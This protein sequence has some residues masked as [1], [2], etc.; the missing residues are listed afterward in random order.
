MGRKY[1]I[2]DEKGTV[3]SSDGQTSFK[4]IEG[5]ELYSYLYSETGKD[6]YF[7]R[8]KDDNGDVIGIEC[9]EE[10]YR[11]HENERRHIAYL[12]KQKEIS[13][14]SKI[15]ANLIVQES[16]TEIE[17]IE[18]IEDENTDIA[19][20]YDRRE[21]IEKIIKALDALTE[22]E[23]DLITELYL[24]TNPITEREYAE[25]IGITQPTVNYRKARILE[26]IKKVL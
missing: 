8:F 1:Y 22:E 6:K 13:G 3:L 23:H 11:A 2:K 17:L 5:K 16:E 21:L 26:K 20:I 24:S 10:A 9:T 18:T 14:F 4:V 7:Y 25:K 12:T 19:E 15:S